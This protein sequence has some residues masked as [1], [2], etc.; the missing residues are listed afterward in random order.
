[1]NAVFHCLRRVQIN[2]DDDD[3]DDDDGGY[4]LKTSLTT[5]T[6]RYLDVSCDLRRRMSS[7]LVNFIFTN[8]CH[9]NSIIIGI[10]ALV[11]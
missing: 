11:I 9:N 10:I 2:D 3:D 7:L 8:Y 1:M 5:S 4:R 6:P